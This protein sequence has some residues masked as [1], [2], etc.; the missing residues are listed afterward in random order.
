MI[1]VVSSRG[2]RRLSTVW[3][4]PSALAV[5]GAYV[6][7]SLAVDDSGR[8]AADQASYLFAFFTPGYAVVGVILARRRPA[9]PIGWLFLV[10]ALTCALA[11]RAVDVGDGLGRGELLP[12]TASPP[13]VTLPRRTTATLT[14]NRRDSRLTEARPFR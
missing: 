7:L 5:V 3:L 13:F 12:G 1:G 11:G 2:A 10:A 6:L 8:S 14:S 9:V 4:V